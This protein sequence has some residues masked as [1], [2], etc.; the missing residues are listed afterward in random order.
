MLSTCGGKESDRINKIDKMKKALQ[1]KFLV[2]VGA[3]R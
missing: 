1:R 2:D 3:D